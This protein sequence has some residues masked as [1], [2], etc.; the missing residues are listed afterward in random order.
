MK[1][2]KQ[3]HLM[4]VIFLLALIIRLIFVIPS[5]NIPS[6]DAASYD[7]LG[8][9]LSKGDGYVNADG[10]PNSF[11]P[12]FYPAFLAIIYKFFGHSYPAVRVIQSIIG[13]I[14]CVLIFLIAGRIGGSSMGFLSSFLF[15][16]Y[17]PFIKSAELLLTE[18][19]FTFILLLII[20]YL[21]KIQE[22]IRNKDCI[23]LGILLGIGLLTRSMMILFPFFIIPVFIY[24]K[25]GPL[26]NIFKK[27]MIVLL[28]LGL[29][30]LP[31]I[32]RNYAVYHKFVPVSTQ[33]G[34]TFYSSYRPP[35]GIFGMLATEDDPVVVEAIKISSPVSSSDFLVKKT[36]NFIVNN[37]RKVL[38]LEFEKIIYLWAPF[39]WEIIGGRWF[40][41]IYAA[42]LPFFAVGFFLS[43]RRFKRFYLIL[44]PII[45]LQITSLIFYGSPRF[46][47]PIEPYLFI[48][49]MVGING[50]WNYI[51]KKRRKDYE[52]ISS[53]TCF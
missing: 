49:S 52:N 35:N 8:L 45:Y 30:V 36:W 13:A 41:F 40:N 4:L 31:W 2:I 25:K 27:Y 18:L 53:D 7:S 51:L 17:P 1:H 14:A 46:R 48:L 38:F 34:I 26:L 44:L 37:P 20:F 23:I 10:S 32:I 33:G 21:F 6:S 16:A 42:M 47:M 43:L 15:A 22:H 19:F 5:K 29:T 9:S 50:I 24:S 3:H 39:D 28:F 12:P 11:R